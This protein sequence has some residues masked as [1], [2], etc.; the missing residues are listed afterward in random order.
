MLHFLP[1][2]DTRYISL[3]LLREKKADIQKRRLLHLLFAKTV[4]PNKEI[5]FKHVVKRARFK[6]Q[7]NIYA[8][9]EL[10]VNCFIL[11]SQGKLDQRE[12]FGR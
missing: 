3:A 2:M 5:L 8:K 12:H 6:H 9:N 11:H 4:Y 7:Q 1:K 10:F